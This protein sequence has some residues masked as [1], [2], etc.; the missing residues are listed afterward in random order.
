MRVFLTKLAD[1]FVSMY[2][3]VKVFYAV[4]LLN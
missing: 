1:N 2:F 3:S 4:T